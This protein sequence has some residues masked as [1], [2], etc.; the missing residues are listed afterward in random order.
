[1][2]R[3]FFEA[4]LFYE[5]VVVVLVFVDLVIVVSDVVGFCQVSLSTY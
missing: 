2:L 1:M 5:G 4:L 3:G